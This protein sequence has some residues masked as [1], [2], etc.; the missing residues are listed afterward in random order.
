MR[1]KR[2]IV[3]LFE[4]KDLF[5]IKHVISIS[6]EE[7][8]NQFWDYLGLTCTKGVIDTFIAQFYNF[9][10]SYMLNEDAQFFEIIIEESEKHFYFTLWN[11]KISLL[12]KEYLK[13]SSHK[14]LYAKNRI[15]IK[16][17]K[18]KCNKEAEKTDN[19]IEKKNK[20][21]EKNLIQSVNSEK[22]PKKQEPYTFIDNDD[23]LDILKLSDDMQEVVIQAKKVGLQK[24]LFIS[25]RS[26]FSLFCLTLRYYSEI[27]PITSTIT[28]FSNLINQNMEKF[29][30]LN[31][32]ELELVEGFINNIDYWAQT[33]FVKGGAS[34][35]FMD[36]S[37]R[38]DYDTIAA[39]ISPPVYESDENS[40]DDIFDF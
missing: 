40:L 14:M 1:E 16:L 6:N 15:S 39:I 33:I 5:S 3:T 20:T 28:E 32:A 19:K 35:Y 8:L 9:A 12:F 17:N 34:L 37:I 21:R 25:L 23:L 18:N 10:L 13:N 29:M 38:A 36:N 26:T 11:K 22:K 27:R 7:D 24:D 4:T 2:K 31:S 30:E